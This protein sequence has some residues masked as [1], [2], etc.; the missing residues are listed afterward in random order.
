MSKSE[1]LRAVNTVVLY[2]FN[3]ES[4]FI[5]NI[6][7]NHLKTHFRNKFNNYCKEDNNSQSAFMKL[8]VGMSLNNQKKVFKHIMENF[9]G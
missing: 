7:D 9:K 6:F 1:Q 3:F 8:Y 5:E 2:S 4:D